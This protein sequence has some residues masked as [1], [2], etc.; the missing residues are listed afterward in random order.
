M[1][2]PMYIATHIHNQSLGRI[3]LYDTYDDA[4]KQAHAFACNTLDRDLLA[5]E[6]FDL[7]ENGEVFVEDDHD[8]HYTFL[9]GVIE[10]PTNK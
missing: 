3:Y 1:K 4:L 9:I 5:S 6:L 2:Y 8:N 10:Y 7:E